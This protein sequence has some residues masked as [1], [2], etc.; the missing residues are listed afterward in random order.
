MD[1]EDFESFR[2]NSLKNSSISAKESGIFIDGFLPAGERKVYRS[3]SP[4]DGK[5]NCEFTLATRVDYDS[6][7]D[8]LS[9][10][11]KEWIEVPPPRR[12]Q[13]VK[14]IGDALLENKKDL[15]ALVS[16]ETGKTVAEGEGEIQE[17][18]D[19]AYFASGLSRQLYGLTITSERHE[20]RLMEVW[21]PVGPIAVISAFNFPSAVW[22]WNAF[23]AAVC[24]DT[25]LWKP[26]T[27]GGLVSIGVMKIIGKVLEREKAP[28]IF[29]LVNGKGSEV[30]E[31]IAEDRR[32]PLVSFTGSTA[33]GKSLNEKVAKR[34]G[35]TIL[36]LGGNNCAIVSRK[37]DLNIALKGVAF[38]SLATTGQRCTSTRRVVVDSE[39]YDQFMK[40]LLDI[41]ERTPVGNPRKTGILVGPLIDQNAVDNYLKTID[42]IRKQGGKILYGGEVLKLKGLEQGYYVKPTLV[43]AKPEMKVTMKETFAPILYAIKYS[44]LQEAIKIHNSVPQGLS[45]SIFTND[46][47]EYEEF[48]SYRGSD[49]GI[50]NINTS[51]A[52]AEIGGAFGGE[53]DTGSGRESGSDAWKAYMKRQTITVNWGKDIPLSQ[54]VRFDLD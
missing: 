17:M 32:I 16:L 42:E 19:I 25:V 10:A 7:M 4:V 8:R 22:S 52:G 20:H 44:T 24:G 15:G 40:K 29:A 53:K 36:E 27:K 26:S 47:R 49:C 37:S 9:V 21:N 31:W 41:Y 46:L 39:I 11:F 13:V 3:V 14:A 34:L 38:G 51:T 28:Q 50:V 33:T 5:L 30:G 48:V 6:A 45:S 23:I 2:K 54:G 12:G 1:H 18:I 43:E 35:R